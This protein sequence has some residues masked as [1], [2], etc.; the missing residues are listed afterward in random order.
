MKFNNALALALLICLMNSGSPRAGQSAPNVSR[1]FTSVNPANIPW[2]ELPMPNKQ[3]LYRKTLRADA[4]DGTGVDLLRY[5]AG[6]VTPI[7][8]HP[9]GHGMYILQGKLVTNHGTFNPGTFVWFPG[10]EKIYHGA[11]KEADAVVLFIRHE[12]FQID[13]VDLASA[14]ADGTKAK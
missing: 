3:S 1:E 4:Q 12:P 11:T 7:H 5:P 8:A 13:F 10:G 9:H 6:V 14:G 2:S